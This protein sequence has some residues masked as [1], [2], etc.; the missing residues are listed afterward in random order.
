MK[1]KGNITLIAVALCAVPLCAQTESGFYRPITLASGT[2]GPQTTT[3]GGGATQ[4]KEVE[5]GGLSK[6]E[7][8]K[9]A[10]N[11]VANIISVPFQ[12][13][14]NFGVGPNDATQYVMNFQ[15]VI[16]FALNE[17]WNLIT[18]SDHVTDHYG[19]L[20]CFSSRHVDRA[21]WCRYWQDCQTRGQ[22]PLEPPTGG[23]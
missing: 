20:E 12:N 11:P 10:Q 14:F 2:A 17:D 6:E 5:E 7:L 16:P 23:V 18:L 21:D 15:P 9:L 8:A 1:T 4:P 13:N 22:A 3:G 19:R